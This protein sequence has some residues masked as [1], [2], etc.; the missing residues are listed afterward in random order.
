MLPTHHRAP[1][2]N[3]P[4]G[5]PIHLVTSGP[6]SQYTHAD[7]RQFYFVDLEEMVMKEYFA[8]LGASVLLKPH[9]QI[10]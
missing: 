7:D 3:V 4:G 10:V 9:H 8:F 1:Y 5:K 2:E 6:H